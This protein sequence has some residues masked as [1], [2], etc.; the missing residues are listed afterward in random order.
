MRRK[1]KVDEGEGGKGKLK[2]S[3]SLKFNMLSHGH[4]DCGKFN[5]SCRLVDTDNLQVDTHAFE[6]FP[7][8]LP[9]PSLPFPPFTF[10]L[11]P[12]G[13]SVHTSKISLTTY[14]TVRTDASLPTSLFFTGR[15]PFHNN[16]RGPRLFV[17]PPPLATALCCR[18]TRSA[19]TR[20][21]STCSATHC[22]CATRAGGGPSQL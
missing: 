2:M 22:D 15:L 19:S 9:P 6:A 11:Q 14:E 21:A 5:L 18:F 1:G 7:S 12:P 4:V 17:C 8:Q 10:R 20:S 13:P 3:D 16:T